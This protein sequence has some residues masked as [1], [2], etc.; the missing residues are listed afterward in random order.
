MQK[1]TFN[2]FRE[3]FNTENK[4]L[5]YIMKNKYK[6]S[7]CPVCGK[8]TSFYKVKSKRF[9]FDT[10]CRHR[11]S[12][13]SDTSLKGIK[14]PLTTVFHIIFLLSIAKNGMSA[15]EVQRY[16]GMTYKTAWSLLNKIRSMLTNN[17]LLSGVIEMDEAFF[18]GLESNKHK[19]KKNINKKGNTK[20]TSCKTT[21]IGL[22][23]RY[24][25]NIIINA[26]ANRKKETIYKNIVNGIE[27]LNLLL[28]DE[29]KAYKAI[30]IENKLPHLV[31]EHKYEWYG[32]KILNNETGEIINVNTNGIEG[33]WAMVKNSLRN[34]Y[35][36]PSAKYLQSYLDEFSF[37][38]NN[39]KKNVFIEMIKRS[40]RIN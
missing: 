30:A 6:Q 27:N 4:C 34:T 2:D 36:R 32:R 22:K 15:K 20:N 1:F 13:L 17:E 5:S 39:R 12:A 18:G 38:F 8:L 28:T 35:K 9:L 21:L 11:F 40:F 25:G 23:S 29:W 10:K 33:T 31:I 37:R 7:K 3:K 26:E 16:F 19:D 24:N 14:T